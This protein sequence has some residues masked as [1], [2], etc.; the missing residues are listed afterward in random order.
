MWLRRSVLFLA[1]GGAE[2]GAQAAGRERP[3]AN[4]VLIVTDG[5]RWQEVFSGAERALISATPGG[6]ADTTR[7]LRDFWRDDAAERR[8]ALLPF[9]WGTIAREGQLIGN[10]TLGSV[11]RLVNSLKF[12]Y[13]GYN[14]IFTG[15]FDPA[16]N[17][18]EF[19]PNPNETVFEWLSRKRGY[20][21]RIAAFATWNA[22]GRIL[23]V[24]RSGLTVRDG[25][26][27][28]FAA[29]GAHGERQSTIDE[30][31]RT[32]VQLWPDNVFDAP[33]HLA[34]KEYIRAKK[35]RVIFIGYGETDEWAHSG[36]YDLLLRSAHQVDAFV[37]DLWRTLQSMRQYRGSTAFII[38]TDHGRGSGPEGWKRH[39]E[40]VEGA[41]NTWIAMIGPGIAATGERGA[42][43]VVTTSQIA[44]TIARVL[45]EDWQ[46]YRPGAGAALPEK[47]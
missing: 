4:V 41:E 22:F 16:I 8:A 12:S 33:M 34:A 29:D 43:P 17:S 14:E 45:G 9:F 47:N 6:V 46:S 38:T 39:G 28:P 19:P 10:Q 35:P 5:L 11:A 27:P 20:S 42:G 31:Y 44:A 1:L 30:L 13:P 24:D 32:S 26:T 2:A 37:A 36:R 40:S 25:W 23:N 21:G 3:A 18:N 7:L 15:A